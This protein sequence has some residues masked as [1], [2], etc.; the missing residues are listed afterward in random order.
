MDFSTLSA[1]IA[2]VLG[3]LVGATAGI[4]GALLTTWLQLRLDRRRAAQ[5]RD[6]SVA[7]AF[8]EAAQQ[9]TIKM[10]SALHSNVLA[11]LACRQPW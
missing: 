9:L 8:A 5:T 6:D 10:A 11:D 2:T 7:K 1:P 3:A 4:S